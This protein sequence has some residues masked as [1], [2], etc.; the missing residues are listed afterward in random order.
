MTTAK[1]KAHP[2]TSETVM[3]AAEAPTDD[4]A[5]SAAAEVHPRDDSPQGE[6]SPAGY[7]TASLERRV[8]DL[9]ADI[10]FL[11]KIHRWPERE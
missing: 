3:E 4:K 6:E 10:A 5:L 7:R 9:E 2:K 11:R 8:A 1:T